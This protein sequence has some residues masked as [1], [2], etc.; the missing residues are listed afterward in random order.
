VDLAG[1]DAPVN[2]AVA[3][4][5]AF[6]VTHV[7][8]AFEEHVIQVDHLCQ[9]HG[10]FI[11]GRVLVRERDVK[12]I[13]VGEHFAHGLT[14]SLGSFL[15]DGD[16]I[17]KVALVD[18]RDV[19]VI[20]RGDLGK[21]KFGFATEFATPSSE[22]GTPDGREHLGL[23]LVVVDIATL[24]NL[25]DG[26]EA[27]TALG[28][29]GLSQKVGP[30]AFALLLS[31]HAFEVSNV[32]GSVFLAAFAAGEATNTRLGAG[33]FAAAIASLALK[34]HKGITA[35]LIGPVDLLSRLELGGVLADQIKLDKDGVTRGTAATRHGIGFLLDDL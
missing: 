31:G 21:A 7:T 26:L 2:E 22:A 29:L 25:H 8:V 6:V 15:G 10:L 1:A 30:I 14:E 9:N 16:V 12:E 24:H 20:F 35:G 33:T 27:T 5:D 34:G 17:S 19:A 3:Q 4:N 18:F 28:L 23:A 13:T 11:G 32:D